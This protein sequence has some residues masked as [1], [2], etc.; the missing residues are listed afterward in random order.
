MRLVTLEDEKIII[1]YEVSE[2]IFNLL[3]NLLK[4]ME[5]IPGR[6]AARR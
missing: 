2:N 5:A 6:E 3:A 4:S 1:R